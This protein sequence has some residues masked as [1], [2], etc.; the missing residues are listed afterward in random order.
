M[1]PPF[2]INLP[3]VIQ[4]DDYSVFDVH[5]LYQMYYEVYRYMS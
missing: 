1:I 2:F 3:S 4:Y 5:S